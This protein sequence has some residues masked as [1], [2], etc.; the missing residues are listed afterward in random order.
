MGLWLEAF[1]RCEIHW[2][3]GQE[4]KH[5]QHT[6]EVARRQGDN[7]SRRKGGEKPRERVR[8][9][10]GKKLVRALCRWRVVE[11]KVLWY[12]VV[13]ASTRVIGRAT[14]EEGRHCDRSDLFSSDD[15]CPIGRRENVLG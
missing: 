10:S 11:A 12:N 4:R 5:K 7:D 14:F 13:D 9:A 3:R 1:G 2:N 6:V 15:H 8:S